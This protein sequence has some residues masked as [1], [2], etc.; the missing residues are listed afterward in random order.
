V[1]AY[2]QTSR[3]LWQGNV[4]G[5]IFDFDQHVAPLFYNDHLHNYFLLLGQA[6]QASV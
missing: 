3:W 6:V 1:S 2:V 4:F 5:F